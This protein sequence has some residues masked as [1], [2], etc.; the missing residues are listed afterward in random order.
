MQD[1]QKTGDRKKWQV[2]MDKFAKKIK[3]F[4]V[5]RPNYT[6][7]HMK[8]FFNLTG[9]YYELTII[10]E[11]NGIILVNSIIPNFIDNLIA[12]MQKR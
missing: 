5:Q 9:D 8:E 11:G 6:L 12:K 10:K 2:K 1:K 7:A 4:F 3:T